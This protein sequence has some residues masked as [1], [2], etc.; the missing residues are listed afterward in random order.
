MQWQFLGGQLLVKSIYIVLTLSPC[1]QNPASSLLVSIMVDS[2][3]QSLI[4]SDGQSILYT[5]YISGMWHKWA[6][7]NQ[8]TGQLEQTSVDRGRAT[9]GTPASST[10]CTYHGLP[11]WHRN[12]FWRRAG[13]CPSLCQ[14]LCVAA[15]GYA[16]TCS[17]GPEGSCPCQRSHCTSLCWSHL[18]KVP[19]HTLA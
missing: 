17:A 3:T 7:G 6:S 14:P 16:H 12:W 9:A 8:S 13:W 18:T 4:G 1:G 19:T 10:Q 15:S 2:D 11:C 5:K